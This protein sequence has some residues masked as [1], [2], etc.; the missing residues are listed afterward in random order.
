MMGGRRR[1]EK[2][3]AYCLVW[4]MNRGIQ[5]DAS[6]HR[7][8]RTR[9]RRGAVS[10]LG[11]THHVS[12]F[13]GGSWAKDDEMMASLLLHH[14]FDDRFVGCVGILPLFLRHISRNIF[15]L[16]QPNRQNDLVKRLRNV[17]EQLQ[18]PAVEPN[19]PDFPGL[20]SLANVLV[21]DQFINHRDKDVRLHTVLAC[22]EIFAVVSHFDSTLINFR[23]LVRG[24]RQFGLGQSLGWMTY[25][26]YTIFQFKFYCRHLLTYLICSV[27]LLVF[28][29]S[30]H[31]SLRSMM[32]RFSKSLPK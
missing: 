14:C 31:P 30:T 27:Y 11:M 19:S 16:L 12:L 17:V 21:A 28:P 6:E 2:M 9:F 20:A 5:H 29:H 1:G 7:R 22:M 4:Q 32:R 24:G 15:T 25:R 10:F 23:W 13:L 18:D 3:A 26:N 8:V